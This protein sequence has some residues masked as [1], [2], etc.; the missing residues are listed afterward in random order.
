MAERLERHPGVRATINV[1]PS[2]LD[3]LDVLARGA[4]GPIR[5]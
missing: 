1:V 5:S 4:G 2:L 3:Q